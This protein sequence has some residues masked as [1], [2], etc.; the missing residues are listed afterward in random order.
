MAAGF[1][2][3]T[4][5]ASTVRAAT[6]E[7]APEGSTVIFRLAVAAGVATVV[8]VKVAVTLPVTVLGAT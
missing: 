3:G 2:V 6:L 5:P 4:G 1:V 8:A 7:P